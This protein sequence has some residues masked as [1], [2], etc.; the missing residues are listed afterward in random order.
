MPD[1]TRRSFIRLVTG[2]LTALPTMAGGL[3]V[4]PRYAHADDVLTGNAVPVDGLSKPVV[5]RRQG[6]EA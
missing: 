5:I 2:A 4:A 6:R 3:I 1:V